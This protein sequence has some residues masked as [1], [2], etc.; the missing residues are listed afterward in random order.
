MLGRIAQGF[1]VGLMLAAGGLGWSA[2]SAEAQLLRPYDPGCCGN[3]ADLINPPLFHRSTLP[4]RPWLHPHWGHHGKKHRH[5]A[6]ADPYRYGG[7]LMDSPYGE[8]GF[9]GYPPTDQWESF[10]M[11]GEGC[12]GGAETF[13]AP[14]GEIAPVPHAPTPL[15]PAGV[16]V[17]PPDDR[18]GP[19]PDNA[20]SPT[21]LR[22]QPVHPAAP[23]AARPIPDT[24]GPAVPMPVLPRSGN[25]PATPSAPSGATGLQFDKILLPEIE[26]LPDA[27]VPIPREA[28]GNRA[29]P[30]GMFRPVPGAARV[31]YA[32]QDGV[33]R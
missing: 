33:L 28:R 27:S 26:E 2:S 32:T 6:P 9:A 15:P 8:P 21:P 11:G 13:Y 7:P 30:A 20:A 1:R 22:A 4:P 3:A 14:Q 24:T 19:R 18:W 31:W 23:P 10:G 5:W 25:P 17:L 16:P 12:C 29:I